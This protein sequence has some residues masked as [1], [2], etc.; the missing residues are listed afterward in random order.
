MSGMAV[1]SAKLASGAY[2]GLLRLTDRMHL[3]GVYVLK[4]QLSDA[5]LTTSPSASASGV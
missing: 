4:T 2:G 1:R 5:I 3:T